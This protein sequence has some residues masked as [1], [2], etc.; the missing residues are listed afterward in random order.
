MLKINLNESANLAFEMQ[1]EGQVSS[2]EEVWLVFESGKG[3]EIRIPADYTGDEIK[4]RVPVFKG[5]MEAGAKTV[6]LELVVDGK[7]YRPLSET[8]N[9]E[10][11]VQIKTSLSKERSVGVAETK[12][13]EIKFTPKAKSAVIAN[14]STETRNPYL[15]KPH[16]QVWMPVDMR[17]NADQILE[18]RNR[19]DAFSGKKTMTPAFFTE[20]GIAFAT[21]SK[22]VAKTVIRFMK[23]ELGVTPKA[24]VVGPSGRPMSGAESAPDNITEANWRKPVRSYKKGSDDDPEVKARRKA[25]AKA[26]RR[27]DQE[28]AEGPKGV[29][30]ETS[31]KIAQAIEYAVANAVP[32]GDPIDGLADWLPSMAHSGR[33]MEY[34][35]MA[36]QR[37][38]GAP[39]YHEYVARTWDLY[40]EG[41]P[42]GWEERFG[43]QNPWR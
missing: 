40:A 11:P 41:D 15:G 24:S 12:E 37:H 10:Q 18:L 14:E 27:R 35:D 6:H 42:E 17:P 28:E 29:S 4:C 9:V 19:F 3:Y 32:D 16:I 5:L 38:L 25:A 22:G 30:E 33:M 13:T 43:G 20:G 23:E 26:Q 1:V 2:V 36:A 8:I 39:N 7:F 31:W 34:L 21:M